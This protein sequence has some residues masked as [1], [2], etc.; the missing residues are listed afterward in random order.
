M[1]TLY[2]HIINMTWYM[3]VYIYILYFFTTTL[4]VIQMEHRCCVVEIAKTANIVPS[5]PWAALLHGRGHNKRGVDLRLQRR[6][7]HAHVK[8]SEGPKFGQMF[9]H[10]GWYFCPISAWLFLAGPQNSS[11]KLFCLSSGRAFCDE[12]SAV[13][14]CRYLPT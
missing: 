12:L 5:R 3:Y 10:F 7:H 14:C 9:D 1:I 6:T 11:G 8:P 2:L 4:F 13:G